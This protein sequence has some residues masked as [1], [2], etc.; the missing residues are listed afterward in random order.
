LGD[1][2]IHELDIVLPLEI[3]STVDRDVITAVLET[4]V[5]L[6]NPFV[7]AA[8]RTRGLSLHATDVHWAHR[9]GRPRIAGKAAHLA[10]ALAGRPWALR[11]LNG[12]GV[13]ELRKRI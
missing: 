4:Q 13:A 7:P 10:S 6:P 8:S 2:V 12:D 5:R 11:E 3:Q 1:H 9:D